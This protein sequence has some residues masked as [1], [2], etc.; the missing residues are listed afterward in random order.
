MI[1][2]SPRAAFFGVMEKV[3]QND[4][5]FP[6]GGFFGGRRYMAVDDKKTTFTILNDDSED[7]T[8][9]L[10]ACEEIEKVVKDVEEL[11]E[12]PEYVIFTQT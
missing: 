6:E 9:L 3:L 7:Y 5:P 1:T 12:E 2:Y 8:E 4:R 11:E 10:E